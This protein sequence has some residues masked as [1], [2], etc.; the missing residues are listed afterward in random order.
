MEEGRTSSRPGYRLFFERLA[1]NETRTRL[2]RFTVA[3]K[4][5]RFLRRAILFDG[6]RNGYFGLGSSPIRNRGH[7]RDPEPRVLRYRIEL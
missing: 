3:V 4:L 1:K 2:G 7:E 5:T 6:E